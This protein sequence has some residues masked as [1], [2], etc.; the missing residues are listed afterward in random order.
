MLEPAVVEIELEESIDMLPIP[1]SMRSPKSK[2]HLLNSHDTVLQ[3][4]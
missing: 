2:L 3:I 4:P 1:P